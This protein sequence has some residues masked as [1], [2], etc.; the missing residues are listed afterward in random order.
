MIDVGKNTHQ[1][2]L[3]V[4]ADVRHRLNSGFTRHRVGNPG[5]SNTSDEAR[6]MIESAE[7]AV[8]VI[9]QVLVGFSVAVN[10]WGPS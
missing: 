1:C 5:T 4:V 3:I 6:Y 8:V 2:T 7:I 9:F 10:L